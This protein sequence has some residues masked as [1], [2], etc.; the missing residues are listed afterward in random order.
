MIPSAAR[1]P[2]F[3][4]QPRLRTGKAFGVTQYNKP[5]PNNFF[6]FFF[7]TYEI[8]TL[9]KKK[10]MVLQ[11]GMIMVTTQHGFPCWEELALGHTSDLNSNLRP[12]RVAS[13]ISFTLALLAPDS[14]YAQ[15]TWHELQPVEPWKTDSCFISPKEPHAL[16]QS[17]LA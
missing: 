13:T 14:P 3:H 8:Y 4:R 15:N 9:K 11:L 7:L 12:H 1:S 6:F 2:W 5:S 16:K 17:K 10:K